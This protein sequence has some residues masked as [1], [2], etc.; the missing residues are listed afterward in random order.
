MAL[1]GGPL[2]KV[3]RT[4]LMNTLQHLDMGRFGPIICT[5]N[6]TFPLAEG[7]IQ[8]QVEYEHPT[9]NATVRH[10]PF[11]IIVSSPIF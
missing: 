5:L 7:M 2:L 4:D 10:I 11:H 8:A 3:N 6:P 1:L 9:F